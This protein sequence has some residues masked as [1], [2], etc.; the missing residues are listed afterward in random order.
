M[1][2]LFVIVSVLS[3]AGPAFAQAP[4]GQQISLAASLQRGY[5]GVKQNLTEEI[6]KMP[7]ENFSFKPGR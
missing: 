5:N 4:T 3:V 2:R 7:A 1:K 6:A